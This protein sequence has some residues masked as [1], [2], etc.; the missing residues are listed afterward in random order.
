MLLLRV[1]QPFLNALMY[2]C[3]PRLYPISDDFKIFRADVA[4]S[5]NT[6]LCF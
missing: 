2:V 4:P 3:I 1:V 5:G 6:V